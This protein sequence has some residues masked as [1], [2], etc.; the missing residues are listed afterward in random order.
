[1]ILSFPLTGNLLLLLL[2]FFLPDV[3]LLPRGCGVLGIGDEFEITFHM[4]DSPTVPLR[5]T[6]E[7][8][9]IELSLRP[10]WFNGQPFSVPFEGLLQLFVLECQGV[11]EERIVSV[12]TAHFGR[13][14][15]Q[16][17]AVASAGQKWPDGK[18]TREVEVVNPPAPAPRGSGL[19]SQQRL[20]WLRTDP[21]I[22]GPHLLETGD[23]YVY[24]SWSFLVSHQAVHDDSRKT[25]AFESLRSRHMAER[26][27]EMGRNHQLVRGRARGRD[28]FGH[29]QPR[30]LRR[31]PRWWPCPKVANGSSATSPNARR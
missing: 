3:Y 27:I 21:W 10:Q 30:R 1:M 4:K 22:R 31:L 24:C 5:F 2:S 8:G 14:T 23:G 20:K 26:V 6:F 18:V 12:T 15:G 11:R 16:Y 17:W 29:R 9:G 25:H 7:H 28:A 13:R 19:A